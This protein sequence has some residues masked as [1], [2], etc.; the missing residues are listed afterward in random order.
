[1]KREA[2]MALAGLVAGAAMTGPAFAHGI[3]G[4]RFFP[5]TLATDDPFVADELSLP[6]ISQRSLAASG[7][8]P[9]TL[10]KSTSVDFTKRITSNLGVGF[11][12]NYLRL[13]NEDGS[14]QKGFDN[15]SASVKYQFYKSDAREAIASI[16]VDWDI[17]GSGARSIGAESFSTFTPAVFF[18]KGLGDLPEGLSYLRP[19]AITGS[20]GVAI[21]SRKRST[22]VDDEG[23]V[24]V[25]QHPDVLKLGFAV[26]YSLPYLQS[27]V[28]DIGLREPFNKMIPV[29]EF[30]LQKPIDRGA[31]AFTGTVNPGLI[32]AGRYVQFA[33]EAIVPVNHQTGGGKGLMLQLH[34]FIDDI[35]PRSIGR[36]LL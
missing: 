17:G 21:P 24:T 22:T 28:K 26:E 4:K 10:Q 3:A 12:L 34:F 7:D 15:V 20:A 31:Q 6:L 1:M 30:A 32:W 19:L 16:G 18:G 14:T 27:F 5:A 29:V 23:N 33:V 11:G 13:Q 2:L 36:P 35:F 9:A 8:S 25:E